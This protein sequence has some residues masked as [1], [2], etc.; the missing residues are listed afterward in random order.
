MFTYLAV[1]IFLPF[2]G[3]DRANYRASVLD[4]HLASIDDPL[5]KKATPMNFRSKKQSRTVRNFFDLFLA[6]TLSAVL[7]A[8]PVNSYCF[9]GDL[10]QVSESHCHGKFSAGGSPVSDTQVVSIRIMNTY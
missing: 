6:K 5:A 10:L 7:L 9:F 2:V 4:H 3:Q 1:I 8:L